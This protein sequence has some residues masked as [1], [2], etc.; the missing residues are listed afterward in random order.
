MWH[1]SPSI[2]RS[3]SPHHSFQESQFRHLNALEGWMTGGHLVLGS[4]CPPE[5]LRKQHAGSQA[6]PGLTEAAPL[7]ARP[8]GLFQQVTR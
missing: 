3:L 4:G 2:T 6:H 1:G 5:A 7:G 8:Q